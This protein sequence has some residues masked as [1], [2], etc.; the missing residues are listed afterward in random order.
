MCGKHKRAKKLMYGDLIC[1]LT[2]ILDH[3]PHDWTNDRKIQYFEWSSQIG[4]G[5]GD[6]NL[7]LKELL[8]NLI[9][10]ANLTLV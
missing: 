6:V 10:R 4:E 8:G 9:Q 7:V 3:P 5:L 1:N 2:D